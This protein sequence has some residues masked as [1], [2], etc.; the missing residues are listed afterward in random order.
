MQAQEK[1]TTLN[2]WLPHATPRTELLHG[3][4]YDLR[5]QAATGIHAALCARAVQLLANQLEGSDCAVLSEGPVVRIS[6]STGH[7]PDVSI[8]CGTREG[9][10]HSTEIR[11]TLVIE[12]LSASTASYDRETKVHN[13][14]LK[15]GCVNTVLLID[16]VTSTVEYYGHGVEDDVHMSTHTR[17]DDIAVILKGRGQMFL[18]LSLNALFSGVYL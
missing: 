9:A 4:E 12:V 2:D 1:P 3:Y 14:L 6:E 17:D 13:Y 5:A 16:P 7:I 15:S 8:V 11:P 10:Q 18:D